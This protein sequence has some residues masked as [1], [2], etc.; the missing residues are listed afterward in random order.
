MCVRWVAT[1]NVNYFQ[2]KFIPK[3]KFILVLCVV[4]CPAQSVSLCCFFFRFSGFFYL[5]IF[6]CSADC[7][8][9]IRRMQIIVYEWS[10]RKKS[11]SELHCTCVCVQHSA[12]SNSRLGQEQLIQISNSPILHGIDSHQ[13]VAKFS[14]QCGQFL[15][16]NK[17]FS[18]VNWMSSFRRRIQSVIQLLALFYSF[19]TPFGATNKF[20]AQSMHTSEIAHCLLL[21]KSTTGN[22]TTSPSYDMML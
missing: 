5:H 19:R 7:W 13:P 10:A 18:P 14:F 1:Q 12:L 8:A 2:I 6:F 16:Q 11:P 21:A 15:E 9:L 4:R 20:R 3:V 17:R 22:T